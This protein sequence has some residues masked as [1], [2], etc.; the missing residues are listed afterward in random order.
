MSDVMRASDAPVQMVLRAP[1]DHTVLVAI[2]KWYRFILVSA[3]IAAGLGAGFM[4]YPSRP[5]AIAKVLVKSEQ[6]PD[7]VSGLPTSSISS[8]SYRLLRTEAEFFGSRVVLL[9]VARAVR[10]AGSD[11]GDARQLDKDIETL[12]ERLDITTVPNTTILSAKLSAPKAEDA[13]R[14]L[15]MIVDSYVEQHAVAHGRSTNLSSFFSDETERSQANLRRSEERLRQWQQANN[16]IALESQINAQLGTVADFENRLKRTDV[17]IQG[18]RTQIQTLTRDMAGEPLQSVT[19]QGHMPNPLIG[20]LKSDLATEEA[21]L[22]DV[23]RTPVTDR[24]RVDIA[25]AEVALAETTSNP[26]VY[27][28]KTDLAAAETTFGEM[29]QRHGEQD[30][31]VQE[32]ADEVRRRRQRINAAEANARERLQGL[33][34]ELATAEREAEVATRDRIAGLRAQLAAAERDGDASS[35]T[36]VSPNP[37]REVLNTDLGGARVRL[38]SLL[39]QQSALTEQHGRATAALA[40][41]QEKRVDFE[42]MSRE[43]EVAKTLYL[44]NVKRLDDARTTAGLQKHQLTSIVVIEPAHTFR[45]RLSVKRITMVA[46]LGGLAGVALSVGIAVALEFFNASLRSPRDVELLLGVP[47]VATIPVTARRPRALLAAEHTRG[48]HGTSG[49]TRS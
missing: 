29:R 36:T 21:A 4:L 1:A 34:R 7:P 13:E 15:A 22:R 47:V 37:R 28:L 31:R 5:A 32:K 3:L 24:L 16:I 25:A 49:R 48:S 20:R 9:P 6:G 42:R 8:V 38:A 40:R 17:D 39:S 45:A 14:A 30:A 46:L 43:V 10:A 41:L 2:F 33:R 27:K 35:G 19:S 44:Q 18:T 11:A 26:V 23:K 12:Q